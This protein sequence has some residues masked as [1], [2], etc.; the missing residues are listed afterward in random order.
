MNK[1]LNLLLPIVLSMLVL[2]LMAAEKVKIDKLT[3][4]TLPAEVYPMLQKG[5]NLSLFWKGPEFVPGRGFKVGV[6][7]WRSEVRIT[8]L[9]ANLK[10]RVAEVATP[11]ASYT[12]DLV[13]TGTKAG[14]VGAF[15]HTDG[16]YELE[17]SVRTLEGKLVA[18]FVTHEKDEQVGLGFSLLP[19]LDRTVSG[20]VSELFK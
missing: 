18:A 2:P 7:E 1:Y 3:L 14:V 12:L 16:Y 11:G 10:A 19:G 4:K 15:V 9:S 5:K 6:V 13:V 17:G 8:E 20:I